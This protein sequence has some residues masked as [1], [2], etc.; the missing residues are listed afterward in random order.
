MPDATKRATS[1][2]RRKGLARSGELEEIG[3]SRVHLR[4]LRERGVVERVARGLYVLPGVVLSEQQSLAEAASVVPGGVICLLSALRFHGLTTQNPFEI[5]MAVP[6]KAWRPAREGMKLRLVHMSGTSLSE[7]IEE[8]R[9]SGVT[10][11]VYSAAKTVA[12]CF[13]FRNKIGIDVAVE[14]LKDYSRKYR[15][16]ANELARFARIDRVAQVMRPYLEAIP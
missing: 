6:P 4:R 1:L 7:G 5:W 12:D 15:G 8:H 10:V 13:K 14:S 2:L 9:V 16:R 3:V 11:R